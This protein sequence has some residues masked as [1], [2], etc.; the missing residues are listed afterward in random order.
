MA[1][2]PINIY[3]NELVRTP[4]TRSPEAETNTYVVDPLSLREHRA[5]P[6]GSA[7]F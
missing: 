2:R 3:K 6:F 1:K 7:W 5:R 4:A